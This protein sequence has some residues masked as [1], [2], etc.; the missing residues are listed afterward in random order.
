GGEPRALLV[1]AGEVPGVGKE[2]RQIWLAPEEHAHVETARR[3]AVQ[4][5]EEGAAAVRHLRV[6]IEEGDGDPHAPARLLDGFADATEGRLAVDERL[7]A[8]GLATRVGARARGRHHGHGAGSSSTRRSPAPRPQR[9]VTTPSFA[10]R[11]TGSGC[12]SQRITKPVGNRRGGTK[13]S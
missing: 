8:V 3:G 5:I 12:P 11:G 2:P 6:V 7:H 10:V 1:G 4:D 9:T 13:S